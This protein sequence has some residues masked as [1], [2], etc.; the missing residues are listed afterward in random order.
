LISRE[1]KPGIVRAAG[2]LPG[3]GKQYFYFSKNLRR[4]S[5]L[6]CARKKKL[7]LKRVE[8]PEGFC[9]TG[10]LIREAAHQLIRQVLI[11]E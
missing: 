10:E 6:P 8:K 7:G 4:F 2:T 11:E 9:K 5:F 3:K 1:W